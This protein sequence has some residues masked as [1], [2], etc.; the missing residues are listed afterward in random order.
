MLAVGLHK[1]FNNFPNEVQVVVLVPIEGDT[2]GFKCHIPLT[3]C[4]HCCQIDSPWHEAK[5][6]FLLLDSASVESHLSVQNVYS[7]HAFVIFADQFGSVNEY[8]SS[9]LLA[10]PLGF[11]LAKFLAYIFSFLQKCSPF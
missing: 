10:V 9:R 1:P 11:P 2:I 5:P 3:P 6:P 8:L 7:P 4:I